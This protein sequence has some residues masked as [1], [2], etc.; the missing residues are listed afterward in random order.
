[1]SETG[2][3]LQ[4]IEAIQSQYAVGNTPLIELKNLTK[5]ARKCAKKVKELEYL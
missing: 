4:D 3:T 1:M 5:L 2:Y